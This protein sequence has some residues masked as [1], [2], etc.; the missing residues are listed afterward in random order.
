MRVAGP[1]AGIR[2]LDFSTLVPGPFATLMLAE[3]GADVI[4]VERPPQGDPM[5]MRAAEFGMLNAGKRS[6]AVDLKDADACARLQPLIAQADIVIEQFRPGVMDRLGLGAQSLM[7]ANPRLIYCSING[8]GSSGPSALKAGHD[9]TY[10]AEAGLLMQSTG[11]DG[12]PVMP[13]TMIADIGG[14]AYPAVMNILLALL[15]RERTGCGSRIEIAMADNI[16]PFLYPAFVSAYGEGHWRLP[17][18]SIET[19][20]SPRYALYRTADNRWIA[21]APVEQPFWR[22]FCNA[23][24]LPDLIDAAPEEAAAVKA[25]ISARIAERDARAWMDVLGQSDTGCALVLTYEEA[26]AGKAAPSSTLP[27]L[28][29]PLAPCFIADRASGESAPRLSSDNPAWL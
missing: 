11:S 8:Y 9:L 7:A 14:G 3:A 18:D 28:P 21:A 25:R 2:V 16:Q 17:N 5:R 13:A 22:A 23:V 24:G 12:A 19:G 27:P 29:I 26:M 4:K 20:A 15:Q 1:L 10:T 6:I